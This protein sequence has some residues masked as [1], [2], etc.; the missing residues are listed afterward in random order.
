MLT[1]PVVR[2]VL[3]QAMKQE[4]SDKYISKIIYSG[5]RLI[6]TSEMALL[7]TS[8]TSC[9]TR[10]K[11]WAQNVDSGEKGEKLIVFVFCVCTL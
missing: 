6:R 8:K 2:Y 1:V 11:L 7:V 3:P 4:L 9:K 10:S 5:C